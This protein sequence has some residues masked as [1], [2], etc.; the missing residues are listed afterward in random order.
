[1]GNCDVCNGY[2]TWETGTAY[3]ADEF[4]TIVRMGFEPPPSIKM[5]GPAAVQGWKTG[6]VANS[7]TGWLLCPSCAQRAAR[8]LPK[9]AGSGPAGHVLFETM[10]TDTLLG[11]NAKQPAGAALPVASPLTPPKP[12]A[13]TIRTPNKICPTCHQEIPAEATSCSQCNAA[14]EVAFK[15]YCCT[16]RAVVQ[17]DANGKCLKC[18]QEVLDRAVISTLSQAGDSI[19]AGV[20]GSGE[21]APAAVAPIAAA[22]LAELSAEPLLAPVMPASDETKKCPQCG[23]TIKLAAQVCRFC[24]ARFEI[25]E[26]GYCA[27]CH[28][29]VT[30]GA[31]GSCPVCRGELVDRRMN[32]ALLEAVAVPAKAALAEPVAPAALESVEIQG[33]PIRWWQLYLS[34]HGRIGRKTFFLKGLLPLFGCLAL[35]AL[36]AALIG[37]FSS[38]AGASQPFSDA[39]MAVFVP[40]VFIWFW[41]YLMLIVKRFHD[42]NRSGWNILLWIVPLVGQFIYLFNLIECFFVKGNLVSNRFGPETDRANA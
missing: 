19:L 5:L 21:P 32:S 35:V 34:P 29:L 10:L 2:T 7:T 33:R 28:K 39:G 26:T 8:Y 22:G 23:E 4:R 41:G 9:A 13:E 25:T 14:F 3:T 38:E 37:G 40:A 36:I 11:V 20:A 1:M 18:G 24:N 42:L 16:E 6:L 12:P 30:P 17:A 27:S 15:G 31:S